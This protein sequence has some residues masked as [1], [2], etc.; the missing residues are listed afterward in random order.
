MQL[1]FNSKA[2]LCET[3]FYKMNSCLEGQGGSGLHA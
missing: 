2:E 3:H 1:N